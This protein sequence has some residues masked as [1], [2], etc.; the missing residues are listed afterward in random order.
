MLRPREQ[1]SVSAGKELR[2]QQGGKDCVAGL[3]LETEQALGLRRREAETGHLEVFGANSAQQFSDGTFKHGRE[4][5]MGLPSARD[6][7]R[8]GLGENFSLTS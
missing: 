8:G 7:P 5:T 1:A 3:S 6:L 2:V 4:A